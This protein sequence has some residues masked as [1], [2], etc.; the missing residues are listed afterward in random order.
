MPPTSLRALLLAPAP[1]SLRQHQHGPRPCDCGD[2]A[3]PSR[4]VR[5]TPPP[6]GSAP[7]LSRR[8]PRPCDRGLAFPRHP[9]G[10][11]PRVS[12]GPR[13]RGPR[14]REIVAS[15]SRMIRPAPPPRRSARP[16]PAWPVWP[17]EPG[18]F[19]ELASLITPR[20]ARRSPHANLGSRAGRLRAS[21][22]APAPT[23]P[24]DTWPNATCL[25]RMLRPRAR[26]AMADVRPA[27]D[28]NTMRGNL[29]I[30]ELRDRRDAPAR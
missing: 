17:R 1:S 24:H 16:P 25:R 29:K 3:L 7:G 23:T 15:P 8:G 2:V 18:I 10:P 12:A 11:P 9:Q 13:R 26:P 14:V 30:L 21:R 6:R 4:V 27:S 22:E 5:L 20:A 19:I 28:C